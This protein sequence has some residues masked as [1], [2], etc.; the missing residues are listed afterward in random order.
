MGT[1][2]TLVSEGTNKIQLAKNKIPLWVVGNTAKKDSTSIKGGEFL[3]LVD[4][5]QLLNKDYY[6][7]A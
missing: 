4:H 1:K 3:G 6:T 7:V 2:Q 5:C